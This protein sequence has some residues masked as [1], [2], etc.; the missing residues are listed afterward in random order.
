MCVTTP[1]VTAVPCSIGTWPLHLLKAA[2][3]EDAV[4]SN[5]VQ[6]DC[7]CLVPIYTRV[8]NTG[9]WAVVRASVC[10]EIMFGSKLYSLSQQP[11]D[12]WCVAVVPYLLLSMVQLVANVQ[13]CMQVVLGV[14]PPGVPAVRSLCL[15]LTTWVKSF[16][17]LPPV[18]VGPSVQEILVLMAK[19]QKF[20]FYLPC[21]STR[22]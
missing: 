19:I 14:T 22:P 16:F 10:L 4:P 15:L 18:P 20:G 7:W 5:L 6:S 17:K 1:R 21:C 2:S 3:K 8:E 9:M 13:M 11:E 12:C